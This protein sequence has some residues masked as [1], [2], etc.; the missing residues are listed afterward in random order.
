MHIYFADLSQAPSSSPKFDS[1]LPAQC[2][3]VHFIYVRQRRTNVELLGMRLFFGLLFRRIKS[4]Y[5][6]SRIIS[7]PNSNPLNS[8][9]LNAL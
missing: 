9:N 7:F 4:G 5:K 3:V 8:H 1:L 6:P 2:C